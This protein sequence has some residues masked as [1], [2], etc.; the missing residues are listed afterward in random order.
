MQSRKI[1]HRHQAIGVILKKGKMLVVQRQME[2]FLGGTVGIPGC[3][4]R[5]RADETGMALKAMM[6]GGQPA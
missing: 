2:G 3:P 5:R 4:G 6:V 1:P